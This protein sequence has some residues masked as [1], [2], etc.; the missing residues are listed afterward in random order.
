MHRTGRKN[1]NEMSIFNKVSGI[2]EKVVP[3]TAQ[4]N[5]LKA[6]IQKAMSADV[7]ERHKNDMSSKSWLSRNIRPLT[8]LAFMTAFFICTFTDVGQAKYT[9]IA[10]I[11]NGVIFFYFGS[12][13]FEKTT[14]VTKLFKR[15]K[16]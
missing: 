5:E 6:E 8:L 9:V 10:D 12:R 15:E 16:K 2:I 11:M 3:D 4:K 14:N 13:T 7:N 1:R